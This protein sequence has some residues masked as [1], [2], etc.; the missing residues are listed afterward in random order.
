MATKQV[1]EPDSDTRCE[2]CGGRTEIVKLYTTGW[3]GDE[4]KMRP[5]SGPM[6]QCA[7]PSCPSRE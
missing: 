1:V 4:S 3:A 2:E 5:L 7:D 6:W